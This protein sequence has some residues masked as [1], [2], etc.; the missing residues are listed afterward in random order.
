MNIL[1]KGKGPL[2]M[3]PDPF[4]FRDQQKRK[5]RSKRKKITT[6][7][8]AVADNIKNGNYLACG[9]FGT[10]RIPTA[11]LHEIV[12]QRKRNLGFAGHTSTHDYQILINGN[13]LDRVDV[14]YIIGLEIRGLSKSARRAHQEGLIKV[15]EWSNASLAWRFAAGARGIPFFP[16]FVNIGT[17]TFKYSAACIVECPYTKRPILIV[18]ALNPDVAI[19]HVHKADEIGNC[20][21]KGNTIADIDIA[22]ASK[23]TIVTCE[24]IVST[25]YFRE[26]PE[27]NNIPWLVVDA[28]IPVKYGSYPGNML[29]LYYSDEN[30]LMEWL[31]AEEDKSKLEAFLNKYIYGVNNFEEYLQ[32]CGGEKRINELYMEELLK[33][34]P[35][36]R[37]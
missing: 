34:N 6:V 36:F 33:S 21:I 22:A 31:A 9:G 7:H 30:H 3:P 10:N 2:F 8:K 37:R 14:A 23:V 28:V 29:G 12:R 20:E 25:E 11:I 4:S 17:D 16:T 27:K 24:E 35:N 1:A 18:P 32:K 15:C 26:N 19:I 5:D 13:C